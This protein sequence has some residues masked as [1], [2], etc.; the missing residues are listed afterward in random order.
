MRCVPVAG[1]F[2]RKP[3][4]GG[5]EGGKSVPWDDFLCVAVETLG[6]TPRDFWCL[7]WREF[8]VL[9][10]QRLK[11]SA[12]EAGRLL[13]QERDELWRIGNEAIERENGVT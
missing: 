10:S 12:A 1:G 9:L 4:S 8:S 7:T 5:V 3:S 13:P 2:E 6:L 11:K